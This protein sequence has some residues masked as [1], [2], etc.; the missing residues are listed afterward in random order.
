MS[1]LVVVPSESHIPPRSCFTPLSQVDTNIDSQ[2]QVLEVIARNQEAYRTAYGYNEW[3]KS[4]EVS[5]CCYCTLL[6][7]EEALAFELGDASWPPAS[8]AQKRHACTHFLR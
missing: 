1:A 7:N 8:V 6:A 5:G 3:R 2:A 4:C